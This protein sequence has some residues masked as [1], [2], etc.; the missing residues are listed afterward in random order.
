MAVFYPSGPLFKACRW[1]AECLISMDLS[2]YPYVP[3]LWND[4]SD[5]LGLRWTL[6][7]PNAAVASAV[8]GI[9]V[10]FTIGRL[11]SLVTT[12]FYI[13]FLHKRT[14]TRLDDQAN[15]LAANSDSSG[16]LLFSLLKLAYN[17][18]SKALSSPVFRILLSTAFLIIIL[19]GGAVFGIGKLFSDTPVPIT[20][21]TCGMWNGSQLL[22]TSTTL[23]SGTLYEE[24]STR[25]MRSIPLVQKV[26]SLYSE[27]VDNGKNITC[28]G[29]TDN[30]FSWE[31]I[32][33]DPS[34][35]WFGDENCLHLPNF[36]TILQ[37]A[38]ITPRDLGTTR[39]SQLAVTYISECSH[40][41]MSDLM[42]EGEDSGL[43][44]YLVEVGPSN[45]CSSPGPLDNCTAM[46]YNVE[47]FSK[48]YSL[49]SFVYPWGDSYSDTTSWD[50]M[51]FLRANLN[52]SNFL[53]DSQGSQTLTL[54][55]NRLWGVG[56][57]QR[58]DDPFFLTAT[59]PDG[60]SVYPPGDI[61]GAL[62]CRDQTRIHV[63]PDHL[64][65]GYTEDDVVAIGRWQEIVP[66]F[67]SY[68]NSLDENTAEALSDDMNLFYP[69]SGIGSIPMALHDLV[70]NILRASAT[71][72]QGGIQLGTPENVTTRAEVTRWFGFSVLFRLYSAQ[73]FTSGSD[74]DW[75]SG[76]IPLPT[77]EEGA[78]HWVCSSTLRSSSQYTS[79]N[80]D[81]LIIIITIS[82]FI[83]VV[84]YAL[85]PVLSYLVGW[86]KNQ[87]RRSRWKSAVQGALM[88]HHRLEL[89]QLH[90]VAVEKMSR[91]AGVSG[92]DE[93]EEFIAGGVLEG[94]VFDRMTERLLGLKRAMSKRAV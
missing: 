39:K 91:S 87:N 35:C 34:Y 43:I 23:D 14:K 85:E 77:F 80:L 20:L 38:T 15:T 6:S 37:R 45:L 48:A 22:D 2:P 65:E 61:V 71:V 28:R 7:T 16:G 47:S 57:A 60:S 32:E 78:V 1:L 55:V 67:R 56:S 53:D 64:S 90:Y 12:A 86:Q 46:I 93:E 92:R 17:G 19:Q 18:G 36:P 76:I 44:Y 41:D 81:A 75:G 73:T 42:T 63:R 4:G 51:R 84:S 70:G 24:A 79:L 66:Q 72:E 30:L 26:S 29:P 21:G 13:P 88:A 25:T 58:N 59:E 27:C 83:I 82:V 68:L 9:I 94:S 33:S 31:V 89:L 49:V 52:G 62:A 54:L 8:I 5:R 74:N 69:T 40:V 3:R 50:P 11:A 10:S